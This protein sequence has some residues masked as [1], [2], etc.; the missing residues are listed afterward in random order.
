MKTFLDIYM[1][2]KFEL[3]VTSLG[4]FTYFYG[5]LLIVDLFLILGLPKHEVQNI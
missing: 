5:S 1:N 4:V 3:F 2:K